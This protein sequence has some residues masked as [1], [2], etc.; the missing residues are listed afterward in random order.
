MTNGPVQ[1][2]TSDGHTTRDETEPVV[3]PVCRRGCVGLGARAWVAG[4]GREA[5]LVGDEV[6]PV[7]FPVCRRGCV[8]L[9]AR[10]WVAGRG[11]EAVLVRD[12]V[13]PVSSPVRRRGRAAG[14]GGVAGPAGRGCDAPLGR[15]VGDNRR[16][17]LRRGAASLTETAGR[18]PMKRHGRRAGKGA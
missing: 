8:G 13:G 12:K 5:V 10:A 17:T 3:F 4:C 9:G 14:V 11:R 6:E 7:V 15:T 16:A 1:K 2:D 18:A